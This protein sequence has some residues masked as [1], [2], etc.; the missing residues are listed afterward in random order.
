M[1]GTAPMDVN[2][3]NGTA[4]VTQCDNATCGAVQRVQSERL[5]A[6]IGAAEQ[7]FNAVTYVSTVNGTAP[8]DVNNGTAPMDVNYVSDTAGVRQRETMV[9]P[10]G[11]SAGTFTGATTGVVIKSMLWY[12]NQ[13]VRRMRRDE[14]TSMH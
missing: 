6:G 11:T 12:F 1:N 7:V 5:V 4:G 3:V 14:P 9:T 13:C 8:M 2:S 10:T